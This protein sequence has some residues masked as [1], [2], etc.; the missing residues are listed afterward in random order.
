MNINEALNNYLKKNKYNSLDLKAVLFDM[1]GVLFDS[2]KWHAKSWKKVMDEYNI[3]STEE[4]FYLYEGMVGFATIRH[5]IERDGKIE[6]TEAIID[7]I[8]QKKSKYFVEMNDGAIIP[9]AREM[10]T[11]VNNSALKSVLVT[12]SGQHT[13]FQKLEESFPK[14]FPTNQMVTAYDVK[15]GKPHPEPYLMGLEKA[16]SLKPNQAIVVENAPRGVEAAVAAGIFT[17]AINTGPIDPQVLSNCGA[18]IVYP[19]MESFYND[20]PCILNASTK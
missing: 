12:G 7:E 18:H 5:L 13:L 8:Y 19:D 11:L 6:P 16:G 14:M 2:M 20:F 4:E 10:V 3:P 1:D 9:Y 15:H 17:V